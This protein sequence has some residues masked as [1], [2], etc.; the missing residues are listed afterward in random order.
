MFSL[1]SLF[2]GVKISHLQRFA[3]APKPL[4]YFI[5]H[6]NF[7][8]QQD[9]KSFEQ[10]LHTTPNT[11]FED[12]TFKLNKGLQ[13]LSQNNFNEGVN[14]F[15]QVID[16]Y[17]TQDKTL[18]SQAELTLLLKAHYELGKIYEKQNNIEGSASQFK[19]G[20]DLLNQV[21]ITN[22]V[23]YGLLNNAMGRI[24]LKRQ[25]KE[26]AKNYL[27]KASESFKAIGVDNANIVPQF[28]ENTYMMAVIYGDTGHID[29]ALKLLEDVLEKTEK[30]NSPQT[31]LDLALI[32][33]SIGNMYLSKNDENKAVKFWDKS[34][35]SSIKKYGEESFQTL[36]HYYNIS[37][38]L[39]KRNKYKISQ[40][41]VEKN[42]ELCQ[43][44]FKPNVP[45]VAE[46]FLMGGA[47]NFLTNN[48]D[49]AL[50]C[51]TKAT[52]ILSEYPN[53]YNEQVSFAY[54]TMTEIYLA[55]K[56]V[57]EA[58]QCFE[59][60]LNIAIKIAGPESMKVGELYHFWGDQMKYKVMNPKDALAHYF[61]A[62]DIYRKG[63]KKGEEEKLI[64]LGYDIG[65]LLFQGKYYDK[66]L[67]HLNESLDLT[68]KNPSKS[69]FL[70]DIY[71]AIA[72]IYFQQNKYAESIEYFTKA[73][74]SCS[75]SQGEKKE[76]D[77]YY[78][79]LGLAYSHSGFPE[80]AI[81]SFRKA[82][83]LALEAH[84]KENEKTQLYL[85]FL[86]D[87]YV[88]NHN[89]AESEKL[90][91]EYQVDMLKNK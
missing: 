33:Q 52:N 44:L 58:R 75:K 2:K 20:L 1:R 76:V 83:D 37:Q 30:E 23:E 67:E 8:S 15:K 54:L 73:I 74:D 77:V 69:R 14:S 55:K 90:L 71:N 61:K 57:P 17:Q 27:S 63:V 59:K 38:S 48:Y 68:L 39:I 22:S 32:Y 36:N 26:E 6:K 51:Y 64:S 81:N 62:M 28:I 43:K 3:L 11:T 65:I 24:S 25:N 5:F 35:D 29:Q 84:G 31:E 60:A 19:A 72:S 78:R 12:A 21:K 13:F 91:K 70:E 9:S 47:M 41:Y 88:K 18:L 79:N 82:F 4:P 50:D 46:S 66:A 34:I 85:H 45:K 87:E 49:K 40:K 86:A 80:K 16:V 10:T 53:E 89:Y 42:M 7:S 56:K